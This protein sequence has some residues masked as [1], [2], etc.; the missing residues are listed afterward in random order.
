MRVYARLLRVYLWPQRRRVALLAL[1][2]LAGIGLQ[3]ANP[4]VIRYFIDTT[5]G[6][7][8]QPALLAAGA[9][10]VAFALGAQALTLAGSYLT[11]RVA[12][13]ATNALRYDLLRHCLRLDLEF[14]KTHTPGELIERIDGDVS[15]LAGPLS[16][17]GLQITANSLLALGIVGLLFREDWRLGV[18]LAAYTAAMVTFLMAVHGLAA[19]RWQ[20]LRQTS[21]ELFGYLEERIAGA[22]D[23]RAAGAMLFAIHQLLI[24]SRA[25][26]ERYRGAVVAAS[27]VFNATNVFMAAGYAGGLG[28]GVYLYT[29]GEATIGTTYLIVSYVGM[30]AGP[31]RALQDQARQLQQAGAS[32]R[33]VEALFALRPQV[34]DPP[35]PAPLPAGALSVAL[36][37]VTFGYADS[38]DKEGTAVLR[39][40]TLRL[41]P[42]KVLG[43]LGRTGSG[44]STLTRLLFRLYDPNAG[45][46]QIGGLDLRAVAQ[47]DLRARVGLVTQEV[48]LFQASLRDNLSF[49]DAALPDE[50][51]DAALRE[52]RLDRWAA[53][54]PQGQATPLAAGGQGL[55]A[56]E[57]QLLAFARV[58][59]KDPGL[60]I[61]DEASSRLDPATETLLEQAVGRLL[62]GRTA[63]IIAH[64]LRTVQRADDILILENGRVVEY[65]PRAALAADDGSRYAHLLQAGMDAPEPAQAAA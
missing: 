34:A 17:T 20:A 7:G 56:G 27:A 35:H 16:Q 38:A 42:G 33:R 45:R 60:V 1:L 46:V 58:F 19:G 32:A 25:M 21:G 13:T 55:S 8:S 44:K 48:Q 40:V 57:A 62:E 61:L 52:L 2:V 36:E 63:I 65:G 31:L 18:G 15:A 51:L 59:L 49:F 12:W 54:L 24:Y 4:Q 22:E 47:A 53:A 37:G 3:L 39:E 14:H 5:Q 29:R 26:L 28:L 64:R 50:Q 10:Y 11:Q 6:S 30:L 43:V 9:L 41:P 23:I